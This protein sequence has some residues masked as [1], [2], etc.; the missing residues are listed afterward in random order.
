MTGTSWQR[1][2]S[3]PTSCCRTSAG[4]CGTPRWIWAFAFGL[5]HGFGFA[6][7]LGELGLQ[8]PAIA[9]ALVG[10]NLGIEIGQLMFVAVFLPALM[11]LQRG[12]GAELI[13]RLASLAVA[14]VGAY[15]FVQRVLDG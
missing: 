11:L 6:S 3:R 7:A 15:W 9:R 2:S 14:A 4:R 5:V 12:R 8:G 1:R 13:P 10:F